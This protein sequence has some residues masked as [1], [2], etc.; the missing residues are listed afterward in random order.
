MMLMYD[1][2]PTTCHICTIHHYWHSIDGMIDYSINLIPVFGSGGASGGVSCLL[3]SKC[4]LIPLTDDNDVAADIPPSPEPDES[5]D[6]ELLGGCDG[7][8]GN[9]MVTGTADVGGNA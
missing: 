5:G 2:T 4:T 8:G 7:N 1:M 9:A 6:G 3:S